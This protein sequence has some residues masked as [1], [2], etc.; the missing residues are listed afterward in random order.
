MCPSELILPQRKA[1]LD[2]PVLDLCFVTLPE[3]L[4]AARDQADTRRY[5][6]DEVFHGTRLGKN[7]DLFRRLSRMAEQSALAAESFSA[8][9][10]FLGHPYPNWDVYPTWELEEAWRELLSAQHHDNEEC[11]DLCGYVGERSF[12]RSLALSGGVT[13]RTLNH[14]ARRT[15]TS[16]DRLVVFNPLGWERSPILSDPLSGKPLRI[17][18]IPAFGYRVVEPAAHFAF[19]SQIRVFQDAS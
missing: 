12:E 7:G 15:G 9:G 5:T 2:N 16:A 13:E 11:E 18:P 3:Y 4:E 8:L 14:I 19:T 10:G 17:D 6:L 1:L